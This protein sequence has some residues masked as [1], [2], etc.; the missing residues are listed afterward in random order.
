MGGELRLTSAL[1]HVLQHHLCT[2][3]VT[4]MSQ[5]YQ[6]YLSSIMVTVLVV[7]QVK[8]PNAEIIN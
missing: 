3:I 8:N 6:R 5:K 4:S 1:G 2:S 7:E